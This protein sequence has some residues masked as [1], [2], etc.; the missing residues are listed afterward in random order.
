MQ[1]V[2]IPSSPWTLNWAADYI[3]GFP[4]NGVLRKGPSD[5]TSQY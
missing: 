2:W 4:V 5:L 1:S 3:Q